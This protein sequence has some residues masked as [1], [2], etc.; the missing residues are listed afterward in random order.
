MIVGTIIGVGI[1]NLPTSLSDCGPISIVSLARSRPS[2]LATLPRCAM[3]PYPSSPPN[4]PIATA[5]AV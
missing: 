5:D 2:A 3:P 4:P 1:F